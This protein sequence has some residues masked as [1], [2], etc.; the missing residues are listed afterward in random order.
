MLFIPFVLNVFFYFDAKGQE[1]KEN[2]N[3]ALTDKDNNQYTSKVMLDGKRWMTG[4]LNV[5][6]PGSY[7][8]DDTELNCTKYGRLYTWEVAQQV[9]STL[10]QGWRLPTNEEWE[11]LAR[12]YGGLRE[13]TADKGRA[14]WEALKEGGSAGFSALLGG[15][16]NTEGEYARLNAH[17]FYWTATENDTGTAWFYN[18][19]SG[20]QSLNRH[21]DGEKARAFSVRCIVGK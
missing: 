10:G 7:C 8:Y 20:G 11:E 14:T 3:R 19:G 15:G 5:N 17:G 2:E 9:C 16:R 12:H 21:N 4:N 13:Y 6:V 18:F 1:A